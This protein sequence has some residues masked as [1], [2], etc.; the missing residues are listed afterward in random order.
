MELEGEQLILAPRQRV[1][2]A[3]NDPDVLL[4]CIPG[5]EELQK[6]NDNEME[7][8]LLA[9]VGPVRARFTGKVRISDQVAPNSYTLHFKGSGGAAGI[10]SGQSAVTLHDEGESTRL[11]YTVQAS[12]GGKLGQVGGRLIDAS[13]KKMAADFFRTF[14]EYVAPAPDTKTP[15]IEPAARAHGSHPVTA[16]PGNANVTMLPPSALASQPATA[17]PTA[18]WSGELRRV[19][20]LCIGIALG[21]ALTHMWHV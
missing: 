15:E 6:I 19:L 14:N 13:A 18:A 21:A 10:A 3:L 1:W 16:E 20:W 2:D 4:K 11:H 8:R 12:V 9:K 7:A 17:A 5:C